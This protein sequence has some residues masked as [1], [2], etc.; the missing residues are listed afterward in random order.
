[1]DSRREQQSAAE[2]SWLPLCVGTVSAA[3]KQT[4]QNVN[5]GIVC[6]IE[7]VMPGHYAHILH[8]SPHKLQCL[9]TRG[10]PQCMAAHTC[11]L[12]AARKSPLA[13]HRST[14]SGH[15][16]E[17]SSKAAK[18]HVFASAAPKLLWGRNSGVFRLFETQPCLA[19]PSCITCHWGFDGESFIG[20]KSCS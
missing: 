12:A 16:A 8:Q 15:T 6:H 4:E 10:C 7:C 5:A 20:S 18:H 3:H 1:M 2:G 19:I 13:M 9:C 14:T 17:H 11:T